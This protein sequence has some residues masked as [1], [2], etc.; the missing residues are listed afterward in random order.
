MNT[1]LNIALI[2]GFGIM[3][4]I[5]FRRYFN[6]R[7][8]IT[9]QDK[10][11]NG[12]RIGFGAIEVLAALSLFTGDNATLDYIRIGAMVLACTS[13]MIARDGIGEEG[14]AHGGHLIPWSEVRA[15]DKFEKDKVLEMYFTIESQNPKKPDKYKTIEIDFENSKKELVFEFMNINARRKYT[16]MKRR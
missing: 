5:M 11:W 1:Y 2:A 15:W 7:G 16:R 14:V 3:A 10:T 12:M 4:V 9:I 13:Y 6:I 8:K